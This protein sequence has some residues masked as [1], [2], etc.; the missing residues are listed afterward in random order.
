MKTKKHDDTAV[1]FIEV[2]PSE[3]VQEYNKNIPDAFP[4]VSLK[5][6]EKFRKAYPALFKDNSEWTNDKH[7]KK[8]MDWLVSNHEE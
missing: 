4:H 1:N 5:I 3:F 7:R 6:L 2:S 8:L